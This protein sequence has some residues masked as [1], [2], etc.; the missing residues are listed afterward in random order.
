MSEA[1]R[2]PS[3]FYCYHF[4][5]PELIEEC[6][7]VPQGHSLDDYV[8]ALFRAGRIVKQPGLQRAEYKG[9]D[10]PVWQNWWLFWDDS[11]PKALEQCALAYT[12]NRGDAVVQIKSCPNERANEYH[13][14]VAKQLAMPLL[15]PERLQATLLNFEYPDALRK[16]KAELANRLHVEIAGREMFS[17]LV[18]EIREHVAED[19]KTYLLIY[20]CHELP[21]KIPYLAHGIITY[22]QSADGDFMLTIPK[23]FDWIGTDARDTQALNLLRQAAQVGVMWPV[24]SQAARFKTRQ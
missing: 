12:V 1:A 16:A 15:H 10:Y 8:L 21:A 5:E 11:L 22:A 3:Q 24:N 18:G 14:T 23:G 9:N 19:G 13:G 7:D 20:G 2:T 17:E 6:L 4:P